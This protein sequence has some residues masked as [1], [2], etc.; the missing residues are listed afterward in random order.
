MM[1]SLRPLVAIVAASLIGRIPGAQDVQHGAV[2]VGLDV[3]SSVSSS[4]RMLGVL[5][6]AL[7]AAFLFPDHVVEGLGGR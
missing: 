6:L 2:E 5:V 7:V 3:V 4:L 1:G